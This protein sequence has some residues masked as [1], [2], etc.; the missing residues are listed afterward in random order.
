LNTVPKR[1]AARSRGRGHNQVVVAPTK[2]E[3]QDDDAA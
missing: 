1:V 2:L 3:E